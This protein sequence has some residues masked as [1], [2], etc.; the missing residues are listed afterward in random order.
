MADSKYFGIPFATSGDKATIPEATQPSGAIS[1]TQGFGPDYERD[2]ATDPLAKR[3]P[4]DE[5]NEL[6]FQV[7]NA[8]KYLQLY[9]TPEWYALDGAGNPVSYPLSARVRHDA[10]AGMQAWRSL[11]AS[12]TATPGSDAT[13]WAVDDPFNLSVLE[14]TLAEAIAGSIGTRIITPRRMS[15][16]VQN[17]SWSFGVAAGTANAR[18]LTLSPAPASYYDGMRIYA[19]IPATNTGAA[20]LNVNGLGALPIALVGGAALTGQEIPSEAEFIIS[21]GAA[22]LMNPKPSAVTGIGGYQNVVSSLNTSMPTNNVAVAVPWATASGSQSNFGGISGSVFTFTQGGRYLVSGQMQ[23]SVTGTPN[24][25]FAQ[26]SARIIKNN[27]LPGQGQVAVMG[28][29]LTLIGGQATNSFVNGLGSIDVVPGDTLIF[30]GQS[31]IASGGTYTSGNIS[32]ASLT[33]L[34]TF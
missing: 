12:N 31:F 7:T 10:G 21:S 27:G 8:L 33:L 23:M 5:T 15:S 11:V 3:V 4:R 16:A 25:Q 6:Y 17:G 18:T 34:R 13:K 29:D 28:D 19:R 9:G 1:F 14:A 20:T 30:T 32:S 24:G 2:P 26:S 22:V